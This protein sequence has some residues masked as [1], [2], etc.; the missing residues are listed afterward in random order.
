M[1]ASDNLSSQLFHGSGHVFKPG[2]I[3]EPRNHTGAFA[4]VRPDLAAPYAESA[5]RVTPK[6]ASQGMTQIPMFGMVYEVEHVG[7]DPRTPEQKAH[8]LV[9]TSKE[10]FRVKG[11]HSFVPMKVD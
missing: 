10:G 4:A 7:K 11:V 2:D 8:H 6:T 1:T 9:E 3:V 5:T